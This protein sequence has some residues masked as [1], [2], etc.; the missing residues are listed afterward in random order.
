MCQ[1]FAE[2]PPTL[3]RIQQF[4][5]PSGYSLDDRTRGHIDCLATWTNAPKDRDTNKAFYDQYYGGTGVKNLSVVSPTGCNMLISMPYCGSC[6][7][8]LVTKVAGVPE[9]ANEGDVLCADKG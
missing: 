8:E 7:D 4:G 1:E 6:S 9:F 3:Q 2:S 5:R